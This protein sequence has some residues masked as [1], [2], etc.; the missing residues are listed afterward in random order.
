MQLTA[1][2]IKA[3]VAKANTEGDEGF[4]LYPTFDKWTGPTC[5]AVRADCAAHLAV[6]GVL[7]AQQ[8]V[9]ASREWSDVLSDL[10]DIQEA[11][12]Y[13]VSAP[14]IDLGIDDATGVY[15]WWPA[16]QASDAAPA[17]EGK[18]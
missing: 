11:T 17:G 10:D 3:A 1:E 2:L 8:A 13:A 16:I 6:L 9:E 4:V 5:V 14:G 18:A 12:G 15:I 7:I